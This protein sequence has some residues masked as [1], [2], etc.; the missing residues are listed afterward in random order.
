TLAESQ[1]PPVLLRIPTGAGKTEAAV[2][3]WLY[4]RFG[5]S[6]DAVRDSTPR[7]L[8][9]CLPMRT[10]VEQTVERVGCWLERLGMKDDVGVV[11]LMGGEPRTQWYLHPEK[12]FIVVGTQ[13]MLL[14]RA[15][16]R[17]YGMGY[18][19]WPVEYGLLNNDCLWVMDEVQLMANG[20]PTSTQL[21][22]LRGKLGTFG[23]AQSIWMSATV[24]SD[25]LDTIDHRIPAAD[26]V[27]GLSPADL[28]D[29]RLG[30]RHNA[31]KVVARG[32]VD[33]KKPKDMAELIAEKH[34]SG[35]LTLAIVNTVERAQKLYTELVKPR[36]KLLSG[37]EKVLVHSRFREDDRTAKQK[38][39]AAP[40]DPAGRIVVATQAVEAGVDISARTLITELAPWASMV[41]RF[42]RCNRAGEHDQG[43]VLWVDVGNDTAPYD[44]ED[45]D[46]A[47]AIMESLQGKSVGPAA[48]ED[49]GDKMKDADHLTVIRRRDVVGLF[50]TTPDLSGSYLDVSQYVRGTDETG[51]SVFW[52]DVPEGGPDAGKPKVQHDEI[53]SVPLGSRGIDDYFKKDDERKTWMWDFLD[54]EWREIR[55]REVHPGM[56]LMLNAKQGGYTSEMGWDVSSRE[57]V[58]VVERDGEPEDGQSSEPTNTNRKCWVTLSDHSRNVE[59]EARAILDAL[60][61]HIA[62]PADCAAVA[63]AALYH[64]AGK[65]HDAFQKMLRHGREDAP[66]DE[67]QLAK[68]KGSGKYE[69]GLRHFRHE[70]G[71]ALAVLIHADLPEGETR[72]LAAYLAAAHHGKVRL[73][74]RSLPGERRNNKDSNPDADKLLGY[75][76]SEPET[77]PPVDLG[78]RRRVPETALDMSIAQIGLSD[79]GCR[80]WLER[81]LTLLERFGPFRLAYLEAIVRAADMRA[82]A[83][84]QKE[85]AE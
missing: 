42:G 13:D 59:R 71:S 12:P 27:R 66:G 58:I 6:D 14:S 50:D 21:A 84:E 17:G 3:G 47:R 74:I 55:S 65:A 72:D 37:V 79:N 52:R 35:T 60:S 24:R 36:N 15:L 30:K 8:V 29:P 78:Q 22:G 32:A 61:E 54:S 48:L 43:N 11:K 2:L 68:S 20:L 45:V 73:G 70:I 69:G 28:V 44:A 4:R 76:V 9:Y 80:S 49:M 62:N 19:M 31:R 40:L 81:S 82:S 56:T 5:R 85:T 63:L 83:E 41:Q 34:R 53:V 64:D 46:R 25:W 38:S 67:I 1:D 18:N 7:R 75:R 16:N 23:A 77:L 51:V 26:R 57:T 10:L 33:F 39:I